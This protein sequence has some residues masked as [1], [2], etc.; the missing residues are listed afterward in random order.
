M[1]YGEGMIHDTPPQAINPDVAQIGIDLLQ[2]AATV[3]EWDL[4]PLVALTSRGDS[5][6]TAAH[7]VLIPESS[8]RMAHP[9]VVLIALAD[10][11]SQDK[12]R[13]GTPESC[14]HDQITGV[15]FCFESWGVNTDG[16]TFQQA[17]ELHQWGQSNSYAD[18][19]R[20]HEGR[21][22]TMIDRFGGMGFVEHIR[23]TEPPT[24]AKHGDFSG[25]VVLALQRFMAAIEANPQALMHYP[26][27]MERQ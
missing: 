15:L 21:C 26:E 24:N 25:R 10:M 3:D 14:H 18:H 5:E 9:P 6:P 13:I 19:P 7:P 11:I 8:W 12:M 23:G 27:G 20:G 17:E 22:M 4:P 2:G 16:L 1:D